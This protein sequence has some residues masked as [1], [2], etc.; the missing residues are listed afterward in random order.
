MLEESGISVAPP[1]RSRL[2]MLPAPP[3]PPIEV[4]NRRQRRPD[5]P[6]TGSIHTNQPG[7]AEISDNSAESDNESSETNSDKSTSTSET[8]DDK[9]HDDCA[10]FFFFH[11][12]Y[13]LTDL[14]KYIRYFRG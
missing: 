6:A 3:I 14:F 11:V 9:G 5:P 10:F 1:P 12:T 8:N 2:A 13:Y 4:S 7:G